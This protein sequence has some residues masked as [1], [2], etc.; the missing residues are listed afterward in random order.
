MPNPAFANSGTVS[1]E[2]VSVL[3]VSG[4]VDAESA[5]VVQEQGVKLAE[6]LDA[7]TG[8]VVDLTAVDLLTAAGA[9]VVIGLLTGLSARGIRA[10]FVCERGHPARLALDVAL[11]DTTAW[12][13]HN[14]VD[15]AV[16][17]L[18]SPATIHEAHAEAGALFV[19]LTE[20]LMRAVTVGDVLQRIVDATMAAIPAADLVSMTLRA[21]D[22]H[23]RTAAASA[24]AAIELDELQYRLGEG[25]CH[26]VAT[27]GAPEFV[28]CVNLG[29]GC[30]WPKWSP[31]AVRRGWHSVLATALVTTVGD[32]GLA[33]ALNLFSRCPGGLAEAD[34][35]I[36]LLLATH[37][38]LAIAE[39]DA[40]RRGDLDQ[41]NFR[42]ALDSR[43]TI[44]QA[45]G[46]I[47]V[48]RRCTSDEAFELLRKASQN[49]NVKLVDLA[50]TLTARHRELGPVDDQPER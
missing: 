15:G 23:L 39:T 20:A 26:D 11:A 46:I 35:D 7:D 36:V 6:T 10:A 47:M 29:E 21:A 9:R 1:V 50:A 16:A 30:P 8:V 44:G 14:S 32:T 24:E 37:A 45:K 19:A 25:P 3:R 34:H 28:E 4:A 31:E 17:A 2:P 5:V 12:Q 33:G 40:I 22:G 13:V 38:S 27:A 18:T 41:V 42:A 48:R 49:L 43:D